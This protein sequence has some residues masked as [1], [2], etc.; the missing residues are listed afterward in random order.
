MK[1]RSSNS[2]S[3]QQAV[4]RPT[5]TARIRL[6]SERDF[7]A[8]DNFVANS[9]SGNI[10]QTSMMAKIFECI[11]GTPM[12]L[13]AE[14]EGEIVGGLM[15]NVWF[16]KSKVP[17]RFFSRIRSKYGPVVADDLSSV[18]KPLVE[19]AVSIAQ[20]LRPIEHYLLCSR[21]CRDVLGPLGYG[22]AET[23]SQ[24]FLV[25]LQFS[26][27]ELWSRLEKRCR[28]AIRK[29]E[30]SNVEVEIATKAD[31][32][33][34]F[35][36]L[37]IENA[38][39][40][41]IRAD[42]LSFINAIWDSLRPEDLA[43]FYF[44]KYRGVPIA[45]SIILRY[46]RRM[47]YYESCSLQQYWQLEGNNLL[48]WH[49]ILDGAHDGFECYDLMGSPRRDETAHPQYGLYLFKKSFGGLEVPLYPYVR[50]YSKVASAIWNRFVIPVYNHLGMSGAV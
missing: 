34:I 44:A 7:A 12:L 4:T 45:A 25:N 9:P 23:V 36:Q 1:I 6:G 47:Y 10:L 27:D 33:R 28:W 40:L 29:A 49:V 38:K 17:L 11:S 26:D 50:A 21:D 14:N 31:A 2:E 18:S 30:E 16:G 32:P 37:M 35:H 5:L 13:L 15:S 48:Q 8:W 19:A 24:T 41:G 3:Q 39:R 43:R 20:N 46:R 22:L 42:P